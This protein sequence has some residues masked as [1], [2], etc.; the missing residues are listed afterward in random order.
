MTA[1]CFVM[2]CLEDD[3]PGVAVGTKTSRFGLVL[4]A[5]LDRLCG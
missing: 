2:G 5:D 4:E 1:V 3:D